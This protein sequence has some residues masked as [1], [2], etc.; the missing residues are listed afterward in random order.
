MVVEDVAP[1]AKAGHKTETL[2]GNFAIDIPS[3]SGLTILLVV[4]NRSHRRQA[5]TNFHIPHEV[6][7][8]AA[9]NSGYVVRDQ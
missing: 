6:H 2:I 7:T 3:L 9:A 8:P 5:V 1:V 4:Q